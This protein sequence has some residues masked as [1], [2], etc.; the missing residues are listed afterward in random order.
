MA[1][2]PDFWGDLDFPQIRTPADILRE[3]AALLGRKTRNLV[4][5]KVYTSVVGRDFIHTLDLVVPTLDDYTYQLIWISHGIEL[6][7]VGTDDKRLNSEPEFT[8]WV[9]RKLSSEET[10]RILASLLA[11][12]KS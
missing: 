8:E 4:E 5:A 1:T 12:A 10:R 11:Q 6:Y 9:H 2:Q 7:P 3:Q